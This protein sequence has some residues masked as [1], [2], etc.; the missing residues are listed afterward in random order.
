MDETEGTMD[1]EGDL[2]EETLEQYVLAHKL[3]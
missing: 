3:K 2:G 1:I